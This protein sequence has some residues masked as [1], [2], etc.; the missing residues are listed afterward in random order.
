MEVCENAMRAT[1]PPSSGRRGRFCLSAARERKAAS[2]L[3]GMAQRLATRIKEMAEVRAG[4]NALVPLKDALI[5]DALKEAGIDLGKARV[6]RRDTDLRSF[7][8]GKVAGDRVLLA[9]GV[10]GTTSAHAVQ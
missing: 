5:S 2:F 3:A 6:G 8:M 1:L 10:Q 7:A 4:G 9:P